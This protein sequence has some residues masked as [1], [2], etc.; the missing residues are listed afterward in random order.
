MAVSAT[1][2]LQ[3]LHNTFSTGGLGP[4]TWGRAEYE[5]Q[6]TFSETGLLCP[7]LDAPQ[8]ETLRAR[9]RSAGGRG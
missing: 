3:Q 9:E 1:A 6:L 2:E 8:A 4:R 7:R 5:L